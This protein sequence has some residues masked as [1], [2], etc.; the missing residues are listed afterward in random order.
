MD[1]DKIYSIKITPAY[2][3]YKTEKGAKYI[4]P[5]MENG[6]L[7]SFKQKFLDN[8]ILPEP[9]EKIF[10]SRM[11]GEGFTEIKVIEASK[12]PNYEKYF[13]IFKPDSNSEDL[14]SGLENSFFFKPSH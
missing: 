4:I 14:F 10:I 2:L 9:F 3:E 8:Q 5:V 12:V 7:A 6:K 11:V 13:E 1:S